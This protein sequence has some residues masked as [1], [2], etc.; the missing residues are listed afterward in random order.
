MRYNN[1]RQKTGKWVA[2]RG[3][4]SLPASDLER[5]EVARYCDSPAAG[6]RPPQQAS[7]PSPNATCAQEITDRNQSESLSERAISIHVYADQV[8]GHPAGR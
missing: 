1:Q 6:W 4:D 8:I 5:S 2:C 7:D 3:D